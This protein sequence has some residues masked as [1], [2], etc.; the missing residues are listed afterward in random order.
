MRSEFENDGISDSTAFFKNKEMLLRSKTCDQLL[1][2]DS[3]YPRKAFSHEATGRRKSEFLASGADDQFCQFRSFTKQLSEC[4]QRLLRSSSDGFSTSELYRELYH[5]KSANKLAGAPYGSRPLHFDESTRDYGKIWLRPLRLQPKAQTSRDRIFMN[6][7]F[8]LDAY[9]DSGVTKEIARALRHLPHINQTRFEKLFDPRATLTRV[10]KT[11]IW[12]QR[13]S[14]RMK[15]LY[16]ARK[17]RQ[18]DSTM[19][20]ALK[21]VAN[22]DS[23]NEKLHPGKRPRL[24]IQE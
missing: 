14:R 7:T 21:R 6:V 23:S 11:V 16:G 4:M 5:T 15:A 17:L 9:P 24:K 1:I 10:F 2:L 22:Q 12:I 20:W 3:A 13:L 18:W 19:F 8:A